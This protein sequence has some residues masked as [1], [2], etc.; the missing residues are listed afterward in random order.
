[1]FSEKEAA[2]KRPKVQLFFDY[3]FPRS[4]NPGGSAPPESRLRGQDGFPYW[5]SDQSPF[6]IS[7][8]RKAERSRPMWSVGDMFTMPPV[9]T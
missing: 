5:T 3:S 1:M 4:R 6:L 9:P 2:R 7:S 8:M